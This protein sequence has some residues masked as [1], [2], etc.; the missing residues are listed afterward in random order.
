MPRRDDGT[1]HNLDPTVHPGLGKA[2][3]W[4]LVDRIAGRRRKSPARAEVPVT[5]PQP[6]AH[7]NA[8]LWLGHATA[9]IS[10]GGL[11]ILTDPVFSDRLGPGVRR[12]VA[13]P[14]N[15]ATLPPL[16]LVAISHNHRDHLD[17][18]S[19]VAVEEAH[20]PHW[21]VPLGVERYLVAWG[22]PAERVTSLDWW[23]ESGPLIDAP[24]LRVTCVPAQH[25]SQRTAFDR[26]KSLWGGFV[27][28]LDRHVVYFAGDS[29]YFDGFSEI[30]RRIG[31]IGMALLPIGAYDPEWFMRPQH[32]NPDEAGQA[33]LDLAAERM[34]SI[35]W[36]TFKLTDEPLNEPPAR[37]DAWRTRTRVEDSRAL[38]LPIGG[39][40][41]L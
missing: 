24:D 25:W 26:N 39:L 23:D 7:R 9:L 28:R 10:L 21:V 16:D 18:P 37:F 22:V 30:A 13:S 20:H 8:V 4:A 29:G 27:F 41:T 3:K 34:V 33:F 19:V 15:A 35:H 14:L 17:K 36:G 2:L 31:P 12:N 11:R 6:D 38:V 5:A 40:V 32:M 1:F